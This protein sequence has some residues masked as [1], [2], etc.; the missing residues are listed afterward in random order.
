M[1][2]LLVSNKSPEVSEKLA[3]SATEIFYPLYTSMM[4]VAARRE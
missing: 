4:K 2:R 1:W 3:A